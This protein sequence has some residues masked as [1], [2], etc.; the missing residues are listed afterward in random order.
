MWADGPGLWDK[1]S[2][3]KNS[4]IE[5]VGSITAQLETKTNLALRGG[6]YAGTNFAGFQEFG[7]HEDFA[8]LSLSYRV[9]ELK[10]QRWPRLACAAYIA[11]QD[12]QFEM[13]GLIRQRL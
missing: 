10:I 11:E 6:G 7:R 2:G 1:K 9:I 12:H 5:T 3:V 13:I 8:N 4:D